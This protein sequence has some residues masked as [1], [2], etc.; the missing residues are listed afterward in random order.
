LESL[1]PTLAVQLGRC[2]DA[3]RHHREAEGQRQDELAKHLAER[4]AAKM[5]TFGT[6]Y[7][8]PPA[9][10]L[11]SDGL[12]QQRQDISALAAVVDELTAGLA[13]KLA[14]GLAEEA[15]A[16]ERLGERLQAQLEELDKTLRVEA[17]ARKDAERMTVGSCTGPGLRRLPAWAF[18]IVSE[19]CSLFRQHPPVRGLPSEMIATGR[20]ASAA[21]RLDGGY[22]ASE[23]LSA[24]SFAGRLTMSRI[25]SDPFFL[26]EAEALR[27]DT[28]CGFGP[29]SGLQ[30]SSKLLIPG[31][32]STSTTFA[33]ADCSAAS[34]SAS[35]VTSMESL[36][37]DF[38][39]TPTARENADETGPDREVCY[40]ADLH[41]LQSNIELPMI[42]V[43]VAAA[44]S[45]GRLNIPDFRDPAG[46]IAA[47]G[48]KI[49]L[50]QAAHLGNSWVYRS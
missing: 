24:S 36:A 11:L 9:G 26:E 20:S 25:N 39:R 50:P 21:G 48:T 35:A 8:S 32:A 1:V 23:Y 14:D 18:G 16:R 6:S 22:E 49:T 19:E 47:P 30:R 46:A 28:H 38:A 7:L 44:N 34:G 31:T 3:L 2:E 29:T 13:A 45:S 40:E 37:S 17:F 43:D 15:S 10:L 4:L 42:L 12:E 33:S 5:H 27:A 41:D